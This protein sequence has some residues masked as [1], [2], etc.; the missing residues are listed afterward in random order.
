MDIKDIRR[1]ALQRL[2]DSRCGG[3]KAEYGRRYGI[4]PTYL[5]QL[6]TGHRSIGEKSARKL[7]AAAGVDDGYL[8]NPINA[9]LSQDQ[10]ADMAGAGVRAYDSL[11][12]LDPEAYAFVPIYDIKLS[13]GNGVSNL[14]WVAREDEEQIAFRRGWYRKKGLSPDKLRAMYVRGRSMEPALSD[15]DTVLI[16]V[17]DTDIIDGDI[18]ALVY[19]H[20][21]YIKALEK[22]KGGVKVIS[23]NPDF[24][25]FEV[26]QDDLQHLRIIGRKVWRAG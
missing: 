23:I 12:E 22:T 6:L 17:T 20:Q 15:W 18:Y 1:A 2:V 10:A 11:D 19:R 9:G 26:P 7:E 4:D 14:T 8:D 24:E 3:S 16:D 21:F 5:S 13:A 25:T